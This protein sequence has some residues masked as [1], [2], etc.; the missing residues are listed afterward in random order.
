MKPTAFSAKEAASL[1]A[2][3]KLVVNEMELRRIVTSDALTGAMTGR[4]WIEVAQ[5]EFVKS[6]RYGS[7]TSIIVFDVDH[8]QRAA[9]PKAIRVGTC[10]AGAGAA[11][12]RPLAQR[13]HIGS[14]RRRE[15][16]G[17]I[18]SHRHVQRPVVAVR[19]DRPARDGRKVSS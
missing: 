12:V 16:R 17:S 14:N 15:V 18:H 1:P 8:F 9:I 19:P 7:E 6:C 4:V 3:V 13:R 10:L 11:L 5:N 2:S